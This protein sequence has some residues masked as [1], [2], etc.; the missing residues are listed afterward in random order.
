MS[1]HFQICNRNVF[2]PAAV[3]G[4]RRRLESCWVHSLF[5][6]W[7]YLFVNLC[8]CGNVSGRLRYG[9]TLACNPIRVSHAWKLVFKVVRA[10]FLV[11]YHKTKFGLVYCVDVGTLWYLISNSLI[12]VRSQSRSNC[13]SVN[14]GYLN[15]NW[16][17]Y[18]VY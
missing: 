15:K 16:Y 13:E 11:E 17:G 1:V 8:S 5:M 9:G 14:L 10:S 6:Y 4:K 18:S 2:M 12:S 3:N 7:L